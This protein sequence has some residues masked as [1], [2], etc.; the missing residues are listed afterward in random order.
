MKGVNMFR[1]KRREKEILSIKD[2]DSVGYLSIELLKRKREK[3]KLSIPELSRKCL[4]P[5][6]T[7][8]RI[9]NYQVSPKITTY[10][11]IANGLGLIRF[12]KRRI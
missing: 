1:K 7:I 4:V 5:C 11:K 10:L 2:L 6:S 3:E 9:E 8:R 12:K